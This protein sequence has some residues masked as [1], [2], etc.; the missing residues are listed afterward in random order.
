MWQFYAINVTVEGGTKIECFI[1]LICYNIK[2][3]T[4]EFPIDLRTDSSN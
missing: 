2:V 4:L 3:Y 1:A